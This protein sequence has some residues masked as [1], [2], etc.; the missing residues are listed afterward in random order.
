MPFLWDILSPKLAKVLRIIALLN[1]RWLQA[2]SCS[3]HRRKG[4]FAIH[5]WLLPSP[6]AGEMSRLLK[7]STE[8]LVLSQLHAQSV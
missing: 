1:F 8:G 6:E 3:P 4:S 7:D 5:T 2:S